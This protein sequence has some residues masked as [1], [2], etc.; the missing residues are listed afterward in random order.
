MKDLI[1]KL[2]REA[3]DKIIKCKKCGWSWKKSDSGSD[4]Y[5]CHKCGHD[6][7]PDNIK[8]EKEERKTSAGVLI[9]CTK[10][11]NIFLLLRNDD[12]PTWS[13]MAGGIEEGEDILDG[14]KREFKEELSLEPKNIRFKKINVE[15]RPDKD[16][17]YYH[18]F[19]SEEFEPT[20]DHENKDW[21]WFSED[22]V[23]T[24]LYKGMN[25]KIKN[26]W[27]TTPL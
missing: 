18:G 10:T 13:L 9:K 6:N 22:N 27:Q 12:N 4:M 26:I 3:I 11:G 16:F 20:L 21:G 5:F 14:L 17:H 15:N 8:E 19:T 25:E 24:P 1:K 2:L 23:P 7:T